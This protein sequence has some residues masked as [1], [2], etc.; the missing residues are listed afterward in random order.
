MGDKNVKKKIIILLSCIVLV[1]PVFAN[2][3]VSINNK[4]NYKITKLGQ[5]RI[6]NIK[7]DGKLI[8]IYEKG[9]DLFIIPND[10]VLQLYNGKRRSINSL[11]K[12]DSKYYLAYGIK[13]NKFNQLKLNYN[14]TDYYIT[15]NRD[16]GI[17]KADETKLVQRYYTNYFDSA[18]N[19]SNFHKPN[20]QMDNRL[21]ESIEEFKQLNSEIKDNDENKIW[22]NLIKVIYNM[23][24]TYGGS[25]SNQGDLSDGKTKCDGFTWIVSNMLNETNIPYRFV[26]VVSGYRSDRNV[27]H[28]L[29]EAKMPDGKWKLLECTLFSREPEESYERYLNKI[30]GSIMNKS[31]SSTIPRSETVLAPIDSS[32]SISKE[33][34]IS[35]VYK[36]G[37]IDRET[38]YENTVEVSCRR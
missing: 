22:E 29:L 30:K 35:K 9:K 1:N 25:S 3:G 10:E 16:S 8:N 11:I 31:K 37:K 12:S 32:L 28:V 38:Q 6:E 26:H 5:T 20:Y 2:S 19:N 17:M 15:L 14:G 21:K 36:K 4:N 18:K 23:N 24:L 34:Y 33:Y 13:D 27:T 7:S